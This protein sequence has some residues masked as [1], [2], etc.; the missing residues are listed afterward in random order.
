M[1][2]NT[3]N[4]N[5]GGT[6]NNRRTG[7]RELHEGES[8]KFNILGRNSVKNGSHVNSKWQKLRK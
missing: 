8:P 7:N 2:F 3:N 5:E 4:L 1:F 6:N